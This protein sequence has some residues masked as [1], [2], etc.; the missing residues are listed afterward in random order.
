MLRTV[1]V[2]VLVIMFLAMS[3]GPI[4]AQTPEPAPGE[5]QVVELHLPYAY[6]ANGDQGYPINRT[7]LLYKNDYAASGLLTKEQPDCRSAI[8]FDNYYCDGGPQAIHGEYHDSIEVE[9][10]EY[11]RG[12]IDFD[13]PFNA[14]VLSASDGI[15]QGAPR[16]CAQGGDGMV[17]ILLN[18]DDPDRQMDIIVRY[19]HLNSVDLTSLGDGV[20][21]AGEPIGAVGTCGGVPPHLHL[22]VLYRIS[23]T[24][25]YEVE[26]RFVDA[27]VRRVHP[28]GVLFPQR[29]TVTGEF[30]YHADAPLVVPIYTP[31][32]QFR[33]D[34]RLAEGTVLYQHNETTPGAT[35]SIDSTVLWTVD[36]P[37]AIGRII[38]APV[39]WASTYPHTTNGTEWWYIQLADGRKGWVSAEGITPYLP[40]TPSSSPRTMVTLSS[41]GTQGDQN[42]TNALLSHDGRYV[43]FSSEA[44]NLVAGDTNGK[45]DVF[46]RDIQT[47]TTERVSVTSSGGNA[48]GASYGGW[49]SADG[50]IVVFNSV[51][52]N[53][54][55]NDTNQR[56]D[57]FIRDTTTDATTRISMLNG[58]QLNLDSLASNLSADGRF[59]IFCVR[60]HATYS[61]SETYVYDRET[62]TVR[63][64]AQQNGGGGSGGMAGCGSISANGRYVVFSASGTGWVSGDTNGKQDVF[65]HDL[66]TLET[67]RVSLGGSGSEGEGNIQANNNSRVGIPGA[68]LS[69]D[70]R[71]VVFDSTAT[72]LVDGDT[73]G[74]YDVF[75]RDRLRGTT[76]R[77]SVSTQGVQGDNHSTS[78]TISLDGRYIAYQSSATNLDEEGIDN[79][80]SEDV[81]VYD[82]LTH[83]TIRVSRGIDN[84]P[85]DARSWGGFFSSDNQFVLFTSVASNLVAGDLNSRNDAFLQP[86]P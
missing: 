83:R 20:V 70:G 85:T 42:T 31:P 18:G 76:R 5:G 51:A 72:N 68:A 39:N 29:V 9:D 40:V 23:P 27:E 47:G 43:G 25:S 48:N 38:Q 36:V 6:D 34:V 13:M 17:D 86:W 78:P 21:Q 7:G 22:A 49:L 63:L 79:N 84:D 50:R 80:L 77:V 59:V 53:I 62:G 24:E 16:G 73:N 61:Y 3:A 37:F 4:A 81:Y 75:V 56:S 12:A 58:M 26:I 1:Y 54:V 10:V 30:T 32:L 64:G 74:K 33:T 41:T 69:A 82:Q 52:R 15:V 28:E 66:E 14:S 60:T 67:E 57:V 44:S 35:V 2:A 8:H 19:L 55:P 11:Q 46:V 71:Y 45:E 65:I